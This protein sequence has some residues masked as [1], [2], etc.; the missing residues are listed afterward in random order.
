MSW[1]LPSLPS[2]PGWSRS[3][4]ASSS[5]AP[6]ASAHEDAPDEDDLD[7]PPPFP[8]PNSAQ[9]SQAPSRASAPSPSLAISPPS[10]PRVHGDDDAPSD[11]NIAILP[12]PIPLGDMA[13]PPSTTKK[14]DFGIQPGG[15][16]TERHHLGNGAAST[17]TTG[18]G[19][20]AKTAVKGK[21][22]KGKV[23]LAPGHSALDWARLT[24]SG[25]NI[26]GTD[27]FPLRVTK[28]ELKLHNKA[29]DAWA[30]FNG[31]VYN[32]TPYLSYHPGGVDELMRVAGRDGT[33]LFMLTHSWVNMEYL[34]QECM[35]GMLVRG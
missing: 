31:K 19:V 6:P 1:L 20:P 16:D 4:P 22:K 12:G 3:T 11:L 8:L 29:D 24:Q 25:Q 9:R 30:V 33:K 2:L 13:P 26:R 32:I 23:A 15:M 35:V 17:T 28:E 5:T 21:G 27:R 10:P 34:L 18:L 14:P 7:V